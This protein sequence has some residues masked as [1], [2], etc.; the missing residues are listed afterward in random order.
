M[1]EAEAE[2]FTASNFVVGYAG[3]EYRLLSWA[4]KTSKGLANINIGM[5]FAEMRKYLWQLLQTDFSLLDRTERRIQGYW[6]LDKLLSIAKTS[7]TTDITLWTLSIYDEAN[8]KLLV[9]FLTYLS[10]L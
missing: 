3:K 9:R 5:P 10:S 1:T 4:S 7:K 6:T 8:A 2:S